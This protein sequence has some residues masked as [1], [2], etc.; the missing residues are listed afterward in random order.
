VAGELEISGNS[1]MADTLDKDLLVQ[2]DAALRQSCLVVIDDFAE[3]LNSEIG[4]PPRTFIEFLIQLEKR[5]SATGRLLLVTDRRLSLT[6][7]LDLRTIRLGPPSEE[8]AIQLLGKMLQMRSRQNEIPPT[9]RLDV[10]RWLGCNPRAFQ[11]L[12]ACLE[13]ESLDELISA[14]Q[15]NWDLKNEVFSP[16]LI[17]ELER[18]FRARTLSRLSPAG[19]LLTQFLSV[20]RRPFTVEGITRFTE[21][22][23]DI[24]GARRELLDLFL[25]DHNG[26]W[27]FLNPVPRELAL[28]R[29]Q[30]DPNHTLD[31]HSLAADH[32]CRHFRAK[33]PIN[34]AAHAVE[35][36]EARYHLTLSGRIDEFTEVA[37]RYRSHLLG[38]V[39]LLSSESTR[40]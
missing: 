24:D 39:H 10:V 19:L 22:I 31:A 3:L 16:T 15:E 33:G 29:L 40:R 34:I 21:R 28:A 13:A 30:A 27:F 7:D 23:G 4:L 26:R 35:F 9:R 25:L 6:D 12:V 14:E 32:Y 11:A 38:N 17:K 2:L 36:V 37:S 5:P 18:R 8:D 1:L 20:Y